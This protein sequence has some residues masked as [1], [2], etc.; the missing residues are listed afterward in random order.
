YLALGLDA[1]GDVVALGPV[2]YPG[3][4]EQGLVEMD[5]P[6]DQRRQD[7]AERLA[8]RGWQE[9]RDAA[10]LQVDVVARAVGQERIAEDHSAA[11]LLGFSVVG[12]GLK[13]RVGGAKPQLV[14]SVTLT[15]FSHGSRYFPA[16]RSCM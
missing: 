1:I 8:G 14:P 6:V 10:V 15:S 13:L 16:A 3:Q 9:G 5:V 11:S 7:E 12:T 4:A 2:R